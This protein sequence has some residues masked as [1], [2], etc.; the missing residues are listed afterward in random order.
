MIK[1]S[2]STPH[3]PDSYC[4]LTVCAAIPA[5]GSISEARDL[6]GPAQADAEV[7]AQLRSTALHDV[8][9]TDNSTEERADYDDGDE[10][11]HIRAARRKRGQ[12]VP[13]SKQQQHF[14]KRARKII[15]AVETSCF[16]ATPYDLLAS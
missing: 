12:P 10:R 9:L 1:Y 16:S 4:V 13:D 6:S 3:E 8:M 11:N 5:D 14:E 2:F 7:S 15:A